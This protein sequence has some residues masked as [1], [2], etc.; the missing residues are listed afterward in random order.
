VVQRG[1]TPV[2]LV[3]A[4]RNTERRSHGVELVGVVGQQMGPTIGPAADGGRLPPVVDVDGQRRVQGRSRLTGTGL[5]HQRPLK[6]Q[7]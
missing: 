1:G 3:P 5:F 6:R 7:A 2:D 4:A